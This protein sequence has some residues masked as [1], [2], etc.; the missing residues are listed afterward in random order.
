ML[1]N[2]RIIEE[3][4]LQV[5]SS[6]LI[7][8][9]RKSLVRQKH[10]SCI[11]RWI[12]TLP[13]VP[14]YW[15][16]ILLSIEGH[17]HG[18]VA[19]SPKGDLI[20]CHSKGGSIVVWDAITGVERYRFNDE[21][22]EISANG[23]A[24]SP[25][26]TMFASTYSVSTLALR[27]LL[28][29][30]THLLEVDGSLQMSRISFSPDSTLLICAT[31]STVYSWDTKSMN[32]IGEITVKSTCM[33]M[34]VINRQ[35]VT[36]LVRS[37]S[38]AAVKR[39]NLESGH[40]ELQLDLGS[41]L[42]F[43]PFLKIQFSPDSTVLAVLFDTKIIIWDLETRAIRHQI[44]IDR[45]FKSSSL[46]LSPCAD[47]VAFR[48]TASTI[49]L[50]DIATGTQVNELL[51]SGYRYIA[52][53]PDGKYLLSAFINTELFDLRIRDQHDDER[54]WKEGGQSSDVHLLPNP[55]KALVISHQSLNEEQYRL[56]DTATSD[57]D[58]DYISVIGYCFSEDFQMAAL[59]Y[60]DKRTV[61]V[62]GK[63]NSSPIAQLEASK[64]VKEICL[65]RNG[66]YLFI[67][68]ESTIQIFDICT[69]VE[70]I[71]SEAGDVSHFVYFPR[72]EVAARRQP[73]NSLSCNLERASN[74]VFPL[75]FSLT[76][77]RLVSIG[78]S[79]S[80]GHLSTPERSLLVER[81]NGPFTE[82]SEYLVIRDTQGRDVSPTFLVGKMS[83]MPKFTPDGKYLLIP[84][85]PSSPPSKQNIRVWKTQEWKE[86]HTI[87]DS[88][89]FLDFHRSIEVSRS[90]LCA[91]FMD[92]KTFKI[93]IWEVATAKQVGL[94]EYDLR[95]S[96]KDPFNNQIAFS[97]DD[98]YIRHSRGRLP[99][100]SLA[101][102]SSSDI[103]VTREWIK[104]GSKDL[105]WLP[106]AYRRARVDV[107]GDV[108]A[109][110][111]HQW[112]RFIRLD[113]DK[114]HWTPDGS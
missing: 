15:D 92:V 75:S 29:G 94:I 20:A 1:S 47:T 22:D 49:A 63:E 100:P 110:V 38:G 111:H 5:Y 74:H 48:K 97:D 55:D 114:T 62:W 58:L 70:V 113:L 45:P 50:I 31:P 102:H 35:V 40:T 104:Q 14:E 81:G 61:R 10:S 88:S 37:D 60:S 4:P 44:P 91:A 18:N 73:H 106:P 42:D 7:F 25:D 9:P 77:H 109:F 51:V 28:T 68:E 85:G 6:A 108:I 79:R 24:F 65:S 53:S 83:A 46:F 69:G 112:T 54:I 67:L 33:N 23:P 3:A 32:R 71:S 59:L 11:P 16:P 98:R 36:I 103:F 30:E 19:F 12:K 99:I 87:G 105:L 52:F 96:L 84:S 39:L 86:M 66:Q 8:T 89:L 93:G 43:V 56:V 78:D 76:G 95:L 21:A 64:D 41:Q 34:V 27:I 80:D 2:R 107:Q 57:I 72:N 17:R 26:S 90:G 13:D 82:T 101:K